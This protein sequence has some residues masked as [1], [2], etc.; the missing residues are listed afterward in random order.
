MME[1]ITMGLEEGPMGRCRSGRQLLE[2]RLDKKKWRGIE[3]GTVIIFLK[4]PNRV[5]ELRVA[6][7][8]VI[9][10]KTF[11]ELL[12]YFDA[13]AYLEPGRTVLQEVESLH[14]RYPLKMR[15]RYPGVVG[16]RFQVLVHKPTPVRQTRGRKPRR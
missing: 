8:E 11:K 15:R 1:T 3:I 13:H 16:I 10:R 14:R 4:E 6:V 9:R 12:E 5:E 2:C 7:L